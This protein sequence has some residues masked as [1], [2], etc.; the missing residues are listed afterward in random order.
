MYILF[1]YAIYQFVLWSCFIWLMSIPSLRQKLLTSAIKYRLVCHT[2]T[3]HVINFIFRLIAICRALLIVHIS[4]Q[5]DQSKNIFF[6]RR[7]I[8]L[9]KS[10][11][12]K[13]YQV[14]VCDMV[15]RHTISTLWPWEDS[16]YVFSHPHKHLVLRVSERINNLR[17]NVFDGDN[18]TAIIFVSTLPFYQSLIVKW[19]SLKYS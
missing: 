9:R 7:Y 10:V 8:L 4:S 6:D 1:C 13:R 5:Y 19:K 17:F 3:N 2:H 18:R 15:C 11:N 14:L 16:P 12:E